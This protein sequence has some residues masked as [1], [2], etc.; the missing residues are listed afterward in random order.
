MIEFIQLLKDWQWGLFALAFL[1]ILAWGN[2][3]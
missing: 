2:K 1:A 3:R